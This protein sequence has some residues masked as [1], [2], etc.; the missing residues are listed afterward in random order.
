ME[1]LIVDA[2]R[3][4]YGLSFHWF[5]I[6]VR[7]PA[8]LSMSSRSRPWCIFRASSFASS[9][10]LV[11]LLS[12]FVNTSSCHLALLLRLAVT[13]FF[14]LCFVVLMMNLGLWRS[15]VVWLGC[16]G[17]LLSRDN[18]I[19]PLLEE[20]ASGVWI[21]ATIVPI[22]QSPMSKR[23]VVGLLRQFL[24]CQMASRTG[25]LSHV[26]PSGTVPGGPWTGP[27]RTANLTTLR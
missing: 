26:G 6:V 2:G 23:N 16:R 12:C 10:C 11:N 18:S 19:S 7:V 17:I 15:A 14:L 13:C 8:H 1:E 3:F 22:C 25:D 21:P 4:S 9:S 27:N 20:P 5:L 24:R